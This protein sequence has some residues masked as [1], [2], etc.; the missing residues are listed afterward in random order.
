MSRWIP[1]LDSQVKINVDGAFINPLL[2]AGMGI[3]FRNKDG[4]V[5]D[6]FG[7]T[8]LASSAFMAEAYA[9]IKESCGVVVSLDL[10]NV[11]FESDCKALVDC[12]SSGSAAPWDCEVLVDDIRLSLLSFST[13]NVCHVN[14]CLNK[15][16]DWLAS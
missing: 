4:R 5:L 14:R 2:P 13:V 12:V 8:F 10:T 3:V 6:G 1:P 16:V 9:L 15:A 7:D 11:V